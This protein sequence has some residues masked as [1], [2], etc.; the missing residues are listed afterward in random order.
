MQTLSVFGFEID[1]REAAS[2]WVFFSTETASV[3]PP[4]KLRQK[5]KKKLGSENGW[6]YIFC[7]GCSSSPSSD[8][9]LERGAIS[10]NEG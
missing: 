1:W 7:W 8:V 2:R 5:K 4:L 6:I 9:L 3:K 10:F